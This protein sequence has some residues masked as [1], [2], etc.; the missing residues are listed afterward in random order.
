[1]GSFFGGKKKGDPRIVFTPLGRPRPKNDLAR[2]MKGTVVKKNGKGKV[3]REKKRGG[4]V[5]GRGWMRAL[6]VNRRAYTRRNHP[7][8][9]WRLLDPWRT[10]GELSC[11]KKAGKV[12]GR[13]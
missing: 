4:K 7:V 3:S 12:D 10:E 11:R 9:E 5:G 2:V 6:L 1:L 13:P 8:K